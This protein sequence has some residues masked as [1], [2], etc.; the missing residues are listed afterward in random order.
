MKYHRHLI[1]AALV[2]ALSAC[3]VST[4]SPAPAAAGT[5]AG[6]MSLVRAQA[7]PPP[8]RLEHPGKPPAT[9]H[10]WIPGRWDL[11]EGRYRWQAGYWVAPRPGHLWQPHVWRQVGERWVQEGGRWEPDRNSPVPLRRG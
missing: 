8:P 1:P 6:P 3:A 10:V 9:G 4:P 11:V 5:Q 7:E 2:T